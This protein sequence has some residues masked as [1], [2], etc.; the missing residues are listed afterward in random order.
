MP[1]R[2]IFTMRPTGSIFSGIGWR[3]DLII[4]WVEILRTAESFAKR[5]AILAVLPPSREPQ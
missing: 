4:R 2:P 3:E 1:M 5:T